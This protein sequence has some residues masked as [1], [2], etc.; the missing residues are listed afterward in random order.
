[1]PEVAPHWFCGTGLIP[2]VSEGKWSSC[3]SAPPQT[4]S[5]ADE[6][7]ILKHCASKGRNA[8]IRGKLLVQRHR[9]TGELGLRVIGAGP[10]TSW[11]WEADQRIGGGGWRKQLITIAVTSME[12]SV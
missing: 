11:I 5:T 7:C 12:V 6:E 10:L 1:M 8:L 9:G 4:G 3:F 2:P